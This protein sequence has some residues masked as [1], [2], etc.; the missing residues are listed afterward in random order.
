MTD[1]KSSLKSTSSLDRIREW[2]ALVRLSL[3]DAGNRDFSDLQASYLQ[4]DQAAQKVLGRSL[5]ACKV[6]EIGYGA[7]PNRLIWF[8]GQGVDITGIDLD[9]PILRGTPGEFLRVYRKN[10]WERALKT[11]TRWFINERQLR[12]ALLAD[13]SRQ[14]G[15]TV[16][17]APQ[18]LVVGNAASEDFWARHHGANYIFS[19]DVFEHIP[20]GALQRILP[21]MA[22]SMDP[23][24]VAYVKPMVYTGICGGH[25]IEWYPHTLNQQ[26]NRL[27]EP[28]EHL[29][30]NRHPANTYLNKL[31]LADYRKLFSMHFDILQETC[32]RPNLGSQFMTPEIR[33]DLIQ[34]PDEELFSN[35]VVFLLRPRRNS[36]GSAG[37]HGPYLD[38]PSDPARQ[39]VL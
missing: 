15:K 35:G 11:V 30:K 24:G 29:R 25:H 9:Q 34:Y 16:Q 23:N 8:F 1:S 12:R 37:N 32:V 27:T 3:A 21:I 19:E 6:I 18:R 5:T 4:H 17:L 14:R 22:A 2:L 39:Q 10:G 7:R 28:W 13:L 36:P 26:R 31:S 20:P 38:M 33:Q